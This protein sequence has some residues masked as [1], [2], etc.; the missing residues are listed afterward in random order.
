MPDCDSRGCRR[1]HE[2]RAVLPTG[3][4]SAFVVA[5]GAELRRV[6]RPG[7]TTEARPQGARP[8]PRGIGVPRRQQG[9]MLV[10][11][12]MLRQIGLPPG[13]PCNVL[14]GAR[15]CRR[16]R[17]GSAVCSVIESRAGVGTSPGGSVDGVM[18]E[19]YRGKCAYATTASSFETQCGGVAGPRRRGGCDRDC[20]GDFGFGGRAAA[21]F[22]QKPITCGGAGI[23]AVAGSPGRTTVGPISGGGLALG[24]IMA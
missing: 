22:W 17:S 3:W 10:Q 24:A 2:G 23:R 12:K 8:A 4:N 15:I 9:D 19:A 1:R 6:H 18:V 7:G 16:T 13:S 20:R 21:S 14:A 11:A 5:V